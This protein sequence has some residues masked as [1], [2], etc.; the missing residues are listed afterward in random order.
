VSD[1][2]PHSPPSLTFVSEDAVA[3]QIEG[4]REDCLDLVRR[5]YLTHD[6]GDSVNPQ[7]GFLR[8]PDQ[9][10]ARII[11][12]P[13]YLGGE[14]G[15]AG[16]KWIA[17]FPDNPRTHGIPRASAV[18]LLNDVVTGYP[19]ACLES[20]VISATRTAASA[21]LAAET[22]S[23]GRTARRVGVVGTGLI[24]RHVWTFLRDLKWDIGGFTLHDLNPEAAH[25]FGA[26]LVAEGAPGYTVADDA[27]QAFT[28][29]DLVVLTTV[30]GE[31]HLH[32]PKLLDHAP[33]VLH[34]SLRDLG[35]DL[36]LAAQNI[37]DDTDHAV[38][39]RTSL[40]LAE[41]A[42]GGRNFITGTLADVL[43][44]KVRTDP[45]R[46]VVFS[47]FGLG[48]LDLAVGSWVHE[49]ARAAGTGRVVDDFFASTVTTK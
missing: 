47:P 12:L 20:S 14:F 35:P 11:S 27:E 19:A 16:L 1:R 48:V 44:G 37:T 43:L 34:L 32:D 41:Q 30:A 26:E 39:E 40:H 5:A 18:L 21:V 33:L 15:V 10:R 4:H 49:R 38:R 36:V 45:S 25:A 42:T 24:A 17:S 7:S 46:P 6:G 22:L 23:G 13:A 9:P 28:E 2:I 8:F 31:P 3:A 29:C